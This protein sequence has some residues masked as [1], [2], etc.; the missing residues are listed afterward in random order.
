MKGDI[1]LVIL[2]SFGRR[3]T[4]ATVEIQKA[5]SNSFESDGPSNESTNS[6]GR[7]R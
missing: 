5:R 7:I 2:D 6:G 3:L 4:N 1:N